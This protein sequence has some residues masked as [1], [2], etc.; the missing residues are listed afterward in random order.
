MGLLPA[1]EGVWRGVLGEGGGGI[2]G[3]TPLLGGPAYDSRLGHLE[4]LD[5]G[6]GVIPDAGCNPLIGGGGEVRGCT[7]E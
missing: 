3:T 2:H 1:S 5:G 7:L 4:V 6:G